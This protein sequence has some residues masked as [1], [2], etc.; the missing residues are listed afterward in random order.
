MTGRVHEPRQVTS[1][2]LSNP[3]Y[4]HFDFDR[5]VGVLEMKQTGERNASN[6][7]GGFPEYHWVQVQVQ[8]FVTGLT[9]GAVVCKIGSS[10]MRWYRVAADEGFHA[11]LPAIV[12][13]YEQ[14][15]R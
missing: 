12:K 13:E 4:E 9:W 5:G 2:A 11:E 7:K 1:L 3:M 15:L 6:W 8:M 14:C 10:D